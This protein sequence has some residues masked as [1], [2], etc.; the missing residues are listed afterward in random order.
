MIKSPKAVRVF[1]RGGA[2]LARNALTPLWIGGLL[3]SNLLGGCVM[4]R[5]LPES[6]PETQAA[7]PEPVLPTEPSESFTEATPPQ[8]TTELSREQVISR[9]KDLYGSLEGALRFEVG[10]SRLSVEAVDE[11]REF[12]QVL[13]R[14]PEVRIQISGFADSQGDEQSN[15]LLSER[16]AEAVREVLM[17]AGVAPEQLKIQGLGE[18]APIASNRTSNGRSLNRRVEIETPSG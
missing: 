17:K 3:A 13:Q 10:E 14:A 7:V 11:L 4:S 8:G 1:R 9:L 5:P 12:A 15:L 18:K 6:R 2:A 16:R